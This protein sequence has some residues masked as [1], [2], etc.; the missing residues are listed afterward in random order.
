[1]QELG[2]L[3]T[4]KPEICLAKILLTGAMDARAEKKKQSE[5]GKII[6]DAEVKFTWLKNKKEGSCSDS[7]RSDH[8]GVAG[9]TVDRGRN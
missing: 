8:F 9:S 2:K 7:D 1:M 4:L 3:L 6:G 5:K